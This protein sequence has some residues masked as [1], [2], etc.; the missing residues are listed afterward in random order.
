VNICILEEHGDVI[1]PNRDGFIVSDE[2]LI[3]KAY[4]LL[5]SQIFNRWVKPHPK[6]YV[7]TYFTMLATWLQVCN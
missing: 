1:V 2:G 5:T 4:K 3:K 6:Y 7:I